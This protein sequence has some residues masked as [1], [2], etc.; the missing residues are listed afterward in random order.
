MTK[1]PP[2]KRPAHPKALKDSAEI[3]RFRQLLDG[4]LS[5]IERWLISGELAMKEAHKRLSSSQH[6]SA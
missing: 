2:D 5:G 3:N 6:K 4:K 1:S